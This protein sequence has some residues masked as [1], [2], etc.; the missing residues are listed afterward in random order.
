MDVHYYDNE[1]IVY[2]N[3]IPMEVFGVFGNDQNIGDSS[4]GRPTRLM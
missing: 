2:M 1:A 3:S 4:P